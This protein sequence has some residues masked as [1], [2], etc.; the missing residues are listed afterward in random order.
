MPIGQTILKHHWGEFTMKKRYTD[1]DIYLRTAPRGGVG[2]SSPPTKTAE[3]EHSPEART[4]AVIPESVDSSMLQTEPQTAAPAGFGERIKSFFLAIP[5]R[6]YDFFFPKILHLPVKKIYPNLPAVPISIAEMIDT[7]GRLLIRTFQT[8]Q[9][10]MGLA[11]RYEI[12]GFTAYGRDFLYNREIRSRRVT[13]LTEL[14]RIISPVSPTNCVGAALELMTGKMARAVENRVGPSSLTDL[15]IESPDQW[16]ISWTTFPEVYQNA[17]KKGLDREYASTL[18]DADAATSQFWPTIATHGLAYNLL[19][20][21]KVGESRISELKSLFSSVWSDSTQSAYQNQRLYLIDMRIFETI[22]PQKVNGF[23]RFTPGSVILLEQDEKTKS[24]TPVAIRISNDG[25]TNSK[26]YSRSHGTTDSAWIYALLA[27]KCSITVWGIWIGH[28]WHWHI[29]TAAM[30]MTMANNLDQKNPV[31]QIL[32]PQSDYLI[33]FDD[34]LMIL[35]GTVAPPTSI[36]SATQFMSLLN[37]YGKGHRFFNDD[38]IATLRR[39]GIQESD[40]SEKTAWDR[41]PL[42]GQTLQVWDA[43]ESYVTTVVNT[44]YASDEAIRSDRNLQKWIVDSGTQGAGNIQG[45]PEKIDNRKILAEILTSL[46]YRIT[47]HGSS[48]LNATPNPAMSF[49]PNFPPC[50]QD[51]TLI[52]PNATVDTKSLMKWLPRTGTI[53]EMMQFYFTFVFSVPYEPFIPL[54]GIDDPDT[55][56]YSNAKCN[57]ALIAFRMRIVSILHELSPEMP[58][59]FQWPLNI[60]T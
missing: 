47:V 17:V 12:G 57:E 16:T 7:L 45:L 11:N 34:V 51:D 31:Y 1:W 39:N 25:G 53:G 5:R 56:F 44:L 41:Y 6:I 35:W 37:T 49:V 27:A 55:L 18:T 48:R 13:D 50:L 15:P 22:K 29:V 2:A 40:F 36:A 8:K 4:A 3:L 59:V 14:Q 38:P 30:V 54:E 28:V 32:K 24:L 21:E 46:I 19:I 10:M 9:S 43:T 52:E 20:L 26:L 33:G 42:V 58:Q 23:T 60:E